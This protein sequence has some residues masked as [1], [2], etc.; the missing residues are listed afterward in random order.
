MMA[1]LA[2]SAPALVLVTTTLVFPRAGIE[3]LCGG[4]GRVLTGS[5]LERISSGLTYRL[6]YRLARQAFRRVLSWW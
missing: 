4:R 3:F 6:E 5:R 1:L 2:K